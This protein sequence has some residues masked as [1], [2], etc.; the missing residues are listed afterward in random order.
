[1]GNVSCNGIEF[2]VLDDELFEVVMMVV[3]VVLSDDGY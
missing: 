1:M 3:K 2:G